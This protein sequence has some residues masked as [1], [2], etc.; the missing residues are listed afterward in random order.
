MFTHRQPWKGRRL[1]IGTLALVGHRAEA[2]RQQQAEADCRGSFRHGGGADRELSVKP[3]LIRVNWPCAEALKYATSLAWI[4][5]EKSFRSCRCCSRV[6]N[7]VK[8]EVA[9]AGV[10]QE[11]CRW[12][13]QIKSV[14]P[15]E[16]LRDGAAENRLEVRSLVG[17]KASACAVDC[18]SRVR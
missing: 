11:R 15:R 4:S 16:C 13:H 6:E 3:F 1:T 5:S 10:E 7:N 9:L 17:C 8:Q 12:E 2:E 14:C 18:C